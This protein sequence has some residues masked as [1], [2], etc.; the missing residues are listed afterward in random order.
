MRYKLEILDQSVKKIKTK[1]QKVWGGNSYVYRSYRGKTG[2]E[3]A[4]P[5]ILNRV[6]KKN[7][8]DVRHFL[9]L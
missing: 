5:P 7:I 8:V 4:P 9:V 2:R 3:G 6:K 1:S